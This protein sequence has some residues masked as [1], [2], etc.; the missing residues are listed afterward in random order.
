M[1]RSRE[2]GEGLFIC[3]QEG[4]IIRSEGNDRAIPNALSCREVMTETDAMIRVT[5]IK[6]AAGLVSEREKSRT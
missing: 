4:G 6:R 2:K 1:M 3:E 5:R